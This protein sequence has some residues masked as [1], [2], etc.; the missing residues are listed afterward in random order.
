MVS[1]DVKRRSIHGEVEYRKK[2]VRQQIL[3]QEHHFDDHK[4]SLGDVYESWMKPQIQK[5]DDLMKDVYTLK[6][7]SFFLEV[8]SE[9]THLGLHLRN[10]HGIDGVCI[11]LSFDTLKLGVPKVAEKL[12]VEKKPLL[13]VADVHHMPFHKGAFDLICCFGSLHHF[14]E[15][16]RAIKEIREVCIEKG[17]F[18]SSYDPLKPF[19]RPRQ[20]ESCSEISYG[21]LENSYT[22]R[23]YVTPLKKYFSKVTVKYPPSSEKLDVLCKIRRLKGTRIAS[24]VQSLMPKKLAL[25][26]RLLWF[27]ID[28]FTSISV[29]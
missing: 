18:I 16:G 24:T 10:N 21:I 17:V 9:N 25:T 19:L 7:P 14:Y 3:S 5:L 29:A 15:L 28:D 13:V 11:D 23:E 2:L 27:G 1:E 20:K 8:G 26:L 12:D 4:T 6:R 22:L